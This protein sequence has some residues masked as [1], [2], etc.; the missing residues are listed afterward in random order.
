MVRKEE[1]FYSSRDNRTNIHAIKWIPQMKQPQFILQVI[2]GMAEHIECYDY[3]ARYMA[4]KGVL[5]VGEDHLGHGG[6]IGEDGMSGYFCKEDPA[7]VVVRDVHRLK[8]MIQEEYPGIPYVIL[9]HSMGSFILRNYLCRYGTG[10]SAAIITGTAYQEHLLVRTAK[11]FTTFLTLFQGE[12]H[13]S[14]FIDNMAF[15]TFN[16]KI[17]HPVTKFD[18]LTKET[19][20]VNSYIEDPMCGFLF[21]LNG[22]YTLFSLIDRL[23]ID[24]NLTL[25]PKKLP[26][27]IA[28]GSEDP[29]SNY[30]KDVAR[31][32]EDYQK[33]GMKN[34]TFRLYE[35]D[36]HEILNELDKETIYEDIF[37]FLKGVL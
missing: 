28:S 36:R 16:K 33:M 4:E 34:V 37:L 17:E 13:K 2:H 30:G 12:R 6:S 11:A 9:G 3:F 7:T 29:V 8:K 24:R 20:R 5:V 22:F 15:G 14:T 21:T 32:Y 23:Y 35:G 26:I 18:W 1:L 10:I 31:L 25:M 27:Y 19:G